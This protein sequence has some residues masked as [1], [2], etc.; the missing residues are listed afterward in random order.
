MRGFELDDGEFV[1]VEDEE[2]EA[3]APRKS[4]DID[5]VR[6]VEGEQI[7]PSY[8]KRG[9]FLLPSGESS[10]AYHLLV[11]TM[12]DT[13][14]VGIASFVMRGH[15]Y[16]VAILAE[17]GILR[18]EIM[19]FHDELRDVSEAGIG[20]HEKPPAAKVKKLEQAIAKLSQK[21]LD[22]AELSDPTSEQLLALAKKKL[23][24][25]Q[26]V[27]EV[28]EPANDATAPTDEEVTPGGGEVVDLMDLIKQRMGVTKRAA[29]KR[30]TKKR[31]TKKRSTK[32]R[33]TKRAP[34]R[35]STQ[36]RRSSRRRPARSS[37]SGTRA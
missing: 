11:Q 21:K 13:G 36:P 24:K 19:R 15:Q 8:F 22:P 6:F 35:G 29:K 9:Y 4:R 34:R 27:I 2:L 12:Q 26:D 20:K 16:L 32:K 30:S 17:R 23:A 14:R 3:L 1:V 18:A 10:K 28:S 7:D 25:G 33:S 31:S 37:K 5:L